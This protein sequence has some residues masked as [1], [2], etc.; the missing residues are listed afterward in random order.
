MLAKVRFN[1]L[2]DYYE[3]LLTEKQRKICRY[4]YRKDLSYQEIAE[5]EH[6]S[7][8]AIYDTIRHSRS[9]LGRYEQILHL[10][11]L[12][13]KRSK[14]Y[15]KMQTFAK[16]KKLQELIKKCIQLEEGGEYE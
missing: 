8:A 6:I 16:E 11:A 5:L 7:R 12:G 13:E 4:Y 1:V 14:L 15:Q 9:E 2:L 3:D 10:A